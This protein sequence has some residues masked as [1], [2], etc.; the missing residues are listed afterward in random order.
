[1]GNSR[2]QKDERTMDRVSESAGEKKGYG[3]GKIDNDGER[4]RGG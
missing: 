4:R 3:F 1:M 2:E